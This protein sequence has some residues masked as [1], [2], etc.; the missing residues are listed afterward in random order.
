M[1]TYSNSI[2]QTHGRLYTNTVLKC[3]GFLRKDCLLIEYTGPKVAPLA[4]VTCYSSKSLEGKDLLVYRR[5]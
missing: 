2:A 1:L 3:L 5:P 4:T